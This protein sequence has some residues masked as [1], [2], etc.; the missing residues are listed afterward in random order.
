MQY[1]F[2]HLGDNGLWVVYDKMLEMVDL[3]PVSTIRQVFPLLMSV[4]LAGGVEKGVGVQGTLGL[5]SC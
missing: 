5:P 3:S 1:I 4:F 2:K